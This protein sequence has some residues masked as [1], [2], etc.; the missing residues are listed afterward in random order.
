MAANMGKHLVTGSG[1]AIA[2]AVSRRL[3]TAAA[4]VRAQV[5]SCGIRGERSGS[6]ARFFRVLWFPLPILLPPT[7]THSSSSIIRG[8]YNRPISG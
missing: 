2:Q 6:G 7:A 1:R 5:R 8:W 3:P 4:R